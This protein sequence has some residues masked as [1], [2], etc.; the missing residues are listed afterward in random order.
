MGKS[1]GKGS[2]SLWVHKLKTLEATK[3]FNSSYYS[4]PAVKVGAGIIAGEVYE[5]VNSKG[6]R[7]VGPE[8]VLCGFAGGY[9]QGVGHSQLTSAYGLA[10]DQVLEWEV[11]TPA[12]DYVTATP[13]KHADVYWALAGGGPGTYGVVLSVTVKAYPDGPVAGGT[14]RF[15]NTNSDAYWEAVGL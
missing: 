8:C 9:T 11:V 3:T 15:N 1:T 2:I 4:G 7:V 10:V 6:Y 5:Y 13:E 12:G 14:L